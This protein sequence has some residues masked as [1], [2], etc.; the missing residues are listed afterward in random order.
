[1]LYLQNTKD[2]QVLF[3][4]K[5]GTIPSGDLVFKA[6]STIDL[7]TEVNQVVI[8]LQTS[9]LYFRIAVSLPEGIPDGEYEYSL[10]VGDVRVASGLLVVGENFRPSEY[11]KETTYEQYETE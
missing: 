8:D 1:M 9:G 11:D 5:N 7:E 10:Q 3:V 4:P 6:K 2:A